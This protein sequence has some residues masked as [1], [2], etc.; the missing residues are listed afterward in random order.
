M[1]ASHANQAVI[2]DFLKALEA[3]AKNTNRTPK[4]CSDALKAAAA[5]LKDPTSEKELKNYLQSIDANKLSELTL[6]IVE[7]MANANRENGLLTRAT[8]DTILSHL[9][10]TC[11]DR[12]DQ[13]ADKSLR[14]NTL[15][16]LAKIIQ[17]E[18]MKNAA[19][20]NMNTMAKSSKKSLEETCANAAANSVLFLMSKTS[21]AS[22]KFTTP[23]AKLSNED[24][25]ALKIARP[26]KEQLMKSL[27]P[28]APSVA[29]KP[30]ESKE[31]KQ[32]STQASPPTK[33]TPIIQVENKPSTLPLIIQQ[34]HNIALQLSPLNELMDKYHKNS[35]EVKNLIEFELKARGTSIKDIEKQISKL[36]GKFGEYTALINVAWSKSAQSGAVA[37][38][39][40]NL[41]R[42]TLE[43]SSKEDLEKIMKI[44]DLS[45]PGEVGSIMISLMAAADYVSKENSPRLESEIKTLDGEYRTNLSKTEKSFSDKQNGQILVDQ[46][47]K[48]KETAKKFH[49]LKLVKNAANT[50]STLND[51]S[52]QKE[53]AAAKELM[54]QDKKILQEQEKPAHHKDHSFSLIESKDSQLYSDKI[55]ILKNDLNELLLAIDAGKNKETWKNKLQKIKD[56]ISHIRSNH[57]DKNSDLSVNITIT[58]ELIRLVETQ[59]NFILQEAETAKNKAIKLF[60]AEPPKD[61]LPSANVKAALQ[62]DK[63]LDLSDNKLSASVS[64]I[65]KNLSDKNHTQ[66][67]YQ[68]MLL[69]KACEQYLNVLIKTHT[70]KTQTGVQHDEEKI[71]KLEL[72]MAFL[73]KMRENLNSTASPND[74]INKFNATF[75]TWRKNE[76]LSYTSVNPLK[77][78][79]KEAFISQCTAAQQNITALQPSPAKAG[80]YRPSAEQK[81]PAQKAP[82][83]P[84]AKAD[85]NANT[86]TLTRN[87]R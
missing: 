59:P 66:M 53:L 81:S 8:Q 7:G 74:K 14:D 21:K 75:A 60:D 30:T 73:K 11:L 57:S 72:D 82:A 10:K 32:P 63:K 43:Q 20:N 22:S 47:E 83:S 38:D 68:L 28:S 86:D 37:D 26:L 48:L 56:E 33:Q 76:K 23:E 69:N 49:T 31:Q 15:T 85:A 79:D 87:R 13:N 84:T 3:T 67:A 2:P 25:E 55:D 19:L 54:E 40:I 36:S 64:E 5:A 44:G 41:F 12:L 51:Q 45:L 29:S 34:M 18:A 17:A 1:S 9:C 70:E 35:Q 61:I 46:S 52:L 24:K 77:R 42:G 27:S 58:Q 4:D 39:L 65:T 78:G 71:Q 16:A 80:M 50:L 6:T 62:A